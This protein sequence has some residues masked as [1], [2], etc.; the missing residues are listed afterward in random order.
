MDPD[1]LD[2]A[3]HWWWLILALI[4][5]IAEMIV[6]GVFLIWLGGAALLTGLVTLAFGL[7]NPAQFAIFAV[8]AIGAVYAGRRWLKANPIESS[9]PKLNDRTARL[10]GHNVV[11][12]QSIT[13]GEGRVKVGDSVWNA[14]GPDLPAGTQ[15]RVAGA[16]GSWLIVE[17]L[18]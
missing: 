4:L 17:P 1:Q 6:P 5:G 11:V 15:A 3:A 12:V 18:S 7:P 9:D 10:V 2:L 13:G 8:A 16:D 14:R